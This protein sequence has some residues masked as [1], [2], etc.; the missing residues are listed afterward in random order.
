MTCREGFL[1]FVGGTFGPCT[2]RV[3]GRGP[4]RATKSNGPCEFLLVE[5][6]SLRA[7]V[8]VVA[9][10]KLT[11]LGAAVASLALAASGCS[12]PEMPTVTAPEQAVSPGLATDGA[13]EAEAARFRSFAKMNRVAFPTR[14][15]LGGA[16]VDV[17]ANAVS[18]P[19]YRA[20]T[21]GDFGPGRAFPPGSM[22][23]KA[24][25]ES[26]GTVLTVMYKKA[27]GY[28]SANGDWW[29]GRLADDGRPTAPAFAGKVDFC[30]DC[31]GGAARTD[32]AWGLPA[33]AR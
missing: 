10:M 25:A 23:V 22:L 32:H 18:E 21:S 2:F 29:F 30:I 15:H 27:D 9:G 24:M 17:Y 14:Q 5:S 3:R 20:V 16:M 7:P 8:C 4:S 19:S 26:N 1:A 6:A 12:D 11:R 13:I 28:D 33:D 31:H